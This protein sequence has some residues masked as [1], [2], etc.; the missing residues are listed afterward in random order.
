MEQYWYCILLPLLLFGGFYAQGKIQFL[1][2]TLKKVT[3]ADTIYLL[4]KDCIH[5]KYR[6][7]YVVSENKMVNS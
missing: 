7:R 6:L 1:S 2:K 3:S 4:K 5:E